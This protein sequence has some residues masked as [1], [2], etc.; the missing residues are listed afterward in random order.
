MIPLPESREVLSAPPA[1]FK[2][3]RRASGC[4]GPITNAGV[5]LNAGST[6][7]GKV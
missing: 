1:R 3:G 6:E 5:S 4:V 2:S 7:S